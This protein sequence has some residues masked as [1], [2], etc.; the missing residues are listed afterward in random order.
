MLY[1]CMVLIGR[2]N[3]ARGE[4]TTRAGGHFLVRGLALAVIAV[5]AVFFVQNHDLR[6]D[7]TSEQLS[8]LS[9]YTIKL[10]KDLKADY[11]KAAKLQPQIAKLEEVVKKQE[12]AQEEGRGREE[13]G[14]GERRGTPSRPMPSRSGAR[15]PSKAQPARR[16]SRRDAKTIERPS[17]TTRRR[18][19]QPDDKTADEKKPDEK[20]ADEKKPE[21]KAVTPP[22]PLP[23][24]PRNWPS[25]EKE[26]DK[27]KVQGPVRIDAFISA[28]VPESYVQ[29]RINLLT[30]LREFKALGGDMVELD[31]N[32][33]A[34]RRP[35]GRSGQDPL[36]HRS[37]AKW[38]TTAA[39]RY[40]RDN[41]F[42]GVA[43]TCGLE[44]VVLPFVDRGLPAEYELV[45]SLCTVTRQK[46]KRIGVLETDAHVFGNF[47]QMGMSPVVAAHRGIEEAV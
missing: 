36:Q 34:A 13:G 28:E 3:W 17:R 38:P 20:K 10:V 16:Q 8:S 9:P 4:D 12:A 44:K 19:R 30:V 23:K 31:I 37:P 1:V 43:F 25:C 11:D 22:P 26:F 46:R 5:A 29:T 47:S 35:A 42:M 32:D 41:I 40:K 14:R 21:T 33:D 39:A 18:R 15:R 6:R 45:R 2:R 24:R 7:A 27:L